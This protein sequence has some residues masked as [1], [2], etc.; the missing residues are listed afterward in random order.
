MRIGKAAAVAGLLVA[1]GCISIVGGGDDDDEY[2]RAQ[3]YAASYDATWQAVLRSFAELDLPIATV[4]RESGLVATDWIL[5]SRAD[6]RMD[7]PED[8]RQPEMRFNVLVEEEGSARTR[9]TI[10]SGARALDEDGVLQRCTS[11]GAL[12]RAIQRRVARRVEG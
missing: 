2:R 4:E 9:V 11:T 8:A 3:T 10:T 1:A 12:E 5:V 6:E 7:C